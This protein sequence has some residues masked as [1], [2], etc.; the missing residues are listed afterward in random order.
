MLLT[1]HPALVM[2]KNLE[3]RFTNVWRLADEVRAK[4]T[5]GSHLEGSIFSI[6]EAA[7]VTKK[8]CTDPDEFIDPAL[9]G[10]LV[11]WRP[12]KGIFKFN[13][14]LFES[15]IDTDIKGEVP[16]NILLRM[17][18]WAVYIET[19]PS[20]NMPYPV[21]GFWAYLS[22]Q[23]NQNELILV[24]HLR[25]GKEADDLEFDCDKQ[26][27]SYQLPLGNH[28][29]SD[30]VQMMFGDTKLDLDGDSFQI[31]TAFISSMLSLLLYLCSEEPDI[32]DF[33]P[34]KPIIKYFGKNP[35]LISSK[36][37]V[38]WDVGIRLGAAL[39]FSRTEKNSLSSDNETIVPVRPHIR[40][41]HWHSFWVGKKGEQTIRLKWLPPIAVNTSENDELP[42]VIREVN[43]K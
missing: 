41:A 36:V 19:P 34:A 15:L 40:R 30:L 28:P 25:K 43:N 26:V 17:P 31:L 11:A 4:F 3:G 21:A 39:D 14:A 29:V 42:V 23:G 38:V 24:A 1:D 37:P 8:I 22:R 32:R 13:N 33:N 27:L 10:A 18:S 2:Y 7:L 16:S 12:T 35:R 5:K 20:E 9:V 6:A